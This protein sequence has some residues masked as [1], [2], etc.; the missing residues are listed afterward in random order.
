MGMTLMQQTLQRLLEQYDDNTAQQARA[1]H[2]IYLD[3]LRGAPHCGKEL[4]MVIMNSNIQPQAR[5]DFLQYC[6]LVRRVVSNQ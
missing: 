5:E 6:D 1:V 4:S 3:G 2:G